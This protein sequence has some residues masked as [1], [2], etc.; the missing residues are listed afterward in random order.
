MKRVSLTYLLALSLLSAC[1][2]S[3]P[4]LAPAQRSGTPNPAFAGL[5]V[6]V[7]GDAALKRQGW[8]DYAPAAFGA[9]VRRGDLVRVA[10]SSRAIVACS[11]LNL[12]E[13][14]GGVK[15]YPCITEAQSPLVF[16]GALVSPTRGDPGTGQYPVV[17]AP[18]KTRV[19]SDRPLLQ[20]TAVPGATSYLVKVEG[21]PWQTEVSGVTELAYPVDAPALEPG[22]TYR[23]IVEAGGHSSREESVPGLGFSLLSAAE[24]QRVRADEARARSLG[25]GEEA[26]RL[27]VANLYAGRQ[28]YAEALQALASPGG[29]NQPALAR[30]QGDLSLTVGLVRDAEAAYNDARQKSAASGDREGEALASRGLA[31]VYGLI[32]NTVEATRYYQQARSLYE[33]LGDR[34]A[35]A[36]IDAAMK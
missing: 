11:D 19:L 16:E 17:V 32:G 36:E 14:T 34:Q 23:L 27:L 6:D 28:L 7:S 9:V 35:V 2:G 5:I 1:A 29:S 18:R 8:Q 4:A 21:T 12:A 10:G 25:L 33:Q 3:S 24:V 13:L 31:T 30:L 26:T 15:G 22:K 20:W